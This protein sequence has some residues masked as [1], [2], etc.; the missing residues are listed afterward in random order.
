MTTMVT[1]EIT[2]GGSQNVMVVTDSH[3]GFGCISQ[4]S[5]RIYLYLKIIILI[6]IPFEK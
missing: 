1:K 5:T 6:A 4:D 3:F 2:L